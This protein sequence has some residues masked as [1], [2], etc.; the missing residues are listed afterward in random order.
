MSKALL[1]MVANKAQIFD[2][3]SGNPHVPVSKS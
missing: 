2:P 3:I 1:I